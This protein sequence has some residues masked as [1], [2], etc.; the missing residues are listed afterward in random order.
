MAVIFC[1]TSNPT[2]RVIENLRSCESPGDTARIATLIGESGADRDYRMSTHG[3]NFP[4]RCKFPKS[5]I[6]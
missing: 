1:E 6:E 2:K 5:G 3:A 4:F